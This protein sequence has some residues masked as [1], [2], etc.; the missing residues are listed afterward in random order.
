M[1]LNSE[2]SL[3]ETGSIQFLFRDRQVVLG[4]LRRVPEVR[5]PF[6]RSVLLIEKANSI[7]SLRFR[8]WARGFASNR[9]YCGARI[10]PVLN[11]TSVVHEAV[12]FG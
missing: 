4:P 2:S 6:S 3:M 11:L 12:L 7:L 1:D 8:V 5:N 9:S 10:S